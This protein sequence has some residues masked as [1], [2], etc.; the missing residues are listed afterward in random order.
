MN[1]KLLLT[2]LVALMSA[3]C[4]VA[5]VD[6]SKSFALEMATPY[7]QKGYTVREDFWGG[8][9]GVK[10]KQAISHQLFKGNEYW[11]WV[12]TDVPKAKL[13]VHVYDSDGKL[14]DTES[15]PVGERTA[16]RIIPKR[17]S[18]YFLIVEV[19]KSPEERT[20]WAMVYAYK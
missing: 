10:E 18:N 11:F 7:V 9:L 19:A 4:A 2:G 1:R 20:S 16:V 5:T 13:S 12:A 3:V 14:A 6:D 17:T 15:L 8:D